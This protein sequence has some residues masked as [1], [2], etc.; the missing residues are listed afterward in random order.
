MSQQK[1]V[2]QNQK[3]IINITTSNEENKKDL[4]TTKSIPIPSFL[5]FESTVGAAMLL[6]LKSQSHKYFFISDMEWL[7][8][9]P[10]GL[11]QF[12]LIRSEKNE[13][14]AF[15]AWAK[16]TPEVEERLLKGT[17]KLSPKEWNSG[18]RLWIIYMIAPFGG[19]KP[20]LKKLSETVFKD[21]DI[22]LLQPKSDGLGLEGKLLKDVLK[23]GANND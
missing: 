4:K 18:D 3:E 6:A 1:E 21:Q 19:T 15:I 17:I 23:G 11:N 14:I 13:P 8:L 20:I 22:K 16:I 2:D 9:P 10:I 12:K 5:S 7:I